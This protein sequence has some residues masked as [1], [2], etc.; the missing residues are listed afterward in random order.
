[1]KNESTSLL[2]SI[3][4]K[5]E[6]I[7]I[8]T[9]LI[10][11]RNRKL[12]LENMS[13]INH[14]ELSYNELL[15]FIDE[16]RENL[17]SYKD[18]VDD[19]VKHIAN[20]RD[21]FNEA[22]LPLH[23]NS[24]YSGSILER[25]YSKKLYETAKEEERNLNWNSFNILFFWYYHRKSKKII[26]DKFNS[27]EK[28]ISDEINISNK[29]D[30]CSAPH[31]RTAVINYSGQKNQF[32]YADSNL[33]NLIFDFF[34]TLSKNKKHI[35]E[36]SKCHKRFIDDKMSIICS[37]CSCITETI[38]DNESE[39]NNLPTCNKKTR[40]DKELTLAEF[41]DRILNNIKQR[42]LSAIEHFNDNNEVKEFIN[43]KRKRLKQDIDNEFKKYKKENR[44]IVD[45]EM[46]SF[47]EKKYDE[48]N[49]FLDTVEATYKRQHNK[50]KSIRL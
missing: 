32:V 33:Q 5:E 21:K 1:M 19:I 27:I 14:E 31:K 8:N 38:N 13:S 39:K 17:P 9:F 47:K 12:T 46:I 45:N 2:Y 25:Y 50:E 43:N 37:S 23:I 34:K 28:T 11:N 3:D 6:I 42:A 18:C 22:L 29:N 10:D 24:N 41:K 30:M 48:F 4:E 15:T 20:G 26:I 40:E 36:C 16:M 49:S 44:T 7:L 35:C